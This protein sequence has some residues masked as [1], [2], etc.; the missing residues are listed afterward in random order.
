[1]GPITG[2]ALFFGS[3]TNAGSSQLNTLKYVYIFIAIVV[4]LIALLFFKTWMQEIKEEKLVIDEREYAGKKLFQH[5]HF[6]WAIV[7]QFFYVAAQVGIAALFIN[8]CKEKNIG[9]NP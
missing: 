2:S 4:L 1:L 9:I 6:V 7:A 5:T 3:K 8:Y